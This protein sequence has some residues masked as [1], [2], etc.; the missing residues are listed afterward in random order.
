MD[1][2]NEFISHPDSVDINQLVVRVI[3]FLNSPDLQNALRVLKFTFLGIGIGALVVIIFVILRT[4]WLRYLILEAI[5]EFF[6]YRPYGVKKLTKQWNKIIRRLDR[7]TESEYKLALIE[8]DEL[9]GDTLK[10]MG[11]EGKDLKERLGRF[12]PVSL[13]NIDEVY[14]AHEIRNNVVRDPNYRLDLD[15]VRG[16]LKVYQEALQALQAF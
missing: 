9:L 3:S 14:K 7:R 13:P 6:T 2:V 10:N 8:A 1:K 5:F 15:Q 11:Y 12:T 4:S 16:I